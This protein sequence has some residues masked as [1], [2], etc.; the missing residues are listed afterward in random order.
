[1]PV[2]DQLRK[3]IALARDYL[4]GRVP[5]SPPRAMVDTHSESSSTPDS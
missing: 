4:Q 3:N 5:S 1:M 2:P